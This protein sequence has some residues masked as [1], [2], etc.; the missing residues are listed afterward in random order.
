MSLATE[1]KM[2]KIK[3]Q[4]S[5]I[6]NNLLERESEIS[7]L[8]EWKYYSQYKGL[9][10]QEVVEYFARRGI[11]IVQIAQEDGV[12]IYEYF[13]TKQEERIEEQKIF[14]TTQLQRMAEDK[15][16][17]V[18]YRFEGKL[19]PEVM[20]YF[21]SE[22]VEVI[23]LEEGEETPV[24][25]FLPRDVRLSEEELKEKSKQKVQKIVKTVTLIGV[26]AVLLIWVYFI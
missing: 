9:I 23:P 22:D 8:Q 18:F 10:Y 5:M 13:P 19:C 14:I 4:K 2:Q 16:Q 15:T 12:P 1:L 6:M 26:I 24:Y 7:Y 11:T 17:G 3:Q 25:L 21:K 20:E